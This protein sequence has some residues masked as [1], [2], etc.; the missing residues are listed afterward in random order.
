MSFSS[1]ESDDYLPTKNQIINERYTILCKLGSGTF[2]T[3]WRC[4]DK[5]IDSDV[6]L[7]IHKSSGSYARAA[8]NEAD[9]LKSIIHP[10]VI[11]L[12]DTFIYYDQQPT[13]AKYFCIAYELCNADL[14]KL[15]ESNEFKPLHPEF[16]RN[17]IK[18]LLCGLH[19]LHLNR[20]IHTDLKPE[21]I[22][23]CNDTA[24]IT[25]FST[26][27]YEYRICI[28]VVG[29]R[30]YRAPEGLLG[31]NLTTAMDIWSLGCILFELCTGDI[32][33][34]PRRFPAWKI[35]TTEDHLA[36][37][38]ELLGPLPEWM[39][40]G[41]FYTK[42]FKKSGKFKHIEKLMHWPLDKVLL[43]KYKIDDPLLVDLLEGMLNIDPNKRLTADQ[44]LAHP[45]LEKN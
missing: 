1:V 16:I 4:H 14:L 22:L 28:D 30:Y 21:N 3:V 23:L 10:N 15:I 35:S 37:I 12:L 2:S 44:C 42:Y 39:K 5:I 43:N 45:W 8:K 32:L 34:H 25:D 20:I 9:I 40:N 38:I 36:M 33:F 24:K 27:D 26:A 13:T 7:K 29:T 31:L 6:A 19:E 17:T 41:M 11:K 18:Q